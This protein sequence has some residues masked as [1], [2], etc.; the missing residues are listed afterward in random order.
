MS[1]TRASFTLACTAVG[2]LIAALTRTEA[3]QPV[4]SYQVHRDVIR[5]R[6]TTD[7]GK[8]ISLADI[9]IT[10]APDRVTQFGKSDSAGR[11][12]IV[13]ERGTG[14]YLV[15]IA[16]LGREAFRKRVTRTGAD[17]VFVVDASLKSSVQQLAP[18][19]VQAARTRIP[20]EM[21]TSLPNPVG[22]KEETAGNGVYAT[23]SPDQRGNLDAIAAVVPGISAVSGGGVSVLGLAPSQNGA[24]LNGLAFEGGS[25]P[26]GA[27]T[28]STVASSTYDPSR[29]GF[30]GAQTQVTLSPGD[31]NVSRRAYLTFDSPV[32]QASDPI[33]A[34]AGQQY[35]ALDL[36]LGTA[37]ATNMDRWV[38]NTGL[39]LKRQMSDV[40]SL[41]A[42]DSSVLSHAGV[43]LD[44]VSR[45]L[46]AL[47][48]LGIPSSARGV[49]DSRATDVVNFMGRLDRPLFDYNT[50][51]PQNTTWGITGFANRAHTGALNFSPTATPAHGGE[52]TDLAAGVQADYSAYFG[53]KKDQLND[54]KTGVSVR[55]VTTS[56]YVT[57]PDGR[58]LVSSTLDDARGGVASLAF[59]GNSALDAERTVATW[60]TT[61]ETY[62]F[63]RGIAAHRGK[64]Y[65]DSRLDQYSIDN[66][67]NRLGTYSYNSLADLQANRPASFTRTLSSPTRTG[68]EWSGAL[69]L[70]DNWIKSTHLSMI[71]GARLET[72]AFTSTP[73]ANPDIERLFGAATNHAPNTWHVSPRVG[74]NWYYTSARPVN[75]VSVNPTG[76]FYTVPRGVIRGGIGEFRQNVDPTL[77]SEASVATGLPGGATQLS[78]FGDAV[79]S[80]NWQSFSASE[81]SIPSQC[82]GGS[83]TAGLTDAAPNVLLFDRHY[84]PARSWRGNLGWASAVKSVMYVVDA[85]YAVHLNQPS[86]TDLNFAHASRFTL[87][88]EGDRPVFVPASSIVPASGVIAPAAAR[89]TQQY[90]QVLSRLSDLRGWARQASLRLRPN[91]LF[92]GR[93]NLDATYTF[94]DAH[95][96]SRGFDGTT[97]GDPSRIDWTRADYAPRHEITMSAGFSHPL[98]GV[99]LF[100][101]ATSGLPFTPMVGSDINGDGLANDRA[102]VADPALTTDPAL[103][104]GLRSLLATTSSRSRDCLSDQLNKPAAK[105]SCEGPWTAS[106]NMALS[107]GY[108]LNR[109]LPF[110]SH[111]PQISLYVSNPLGG[112]DQLMHGNSLKGWGTPSFPDRVLYY[113]RGFD[114]TAR[115]FRYEVNP[116]FGNTRPST[117]TLRV[118]FRVTL[119]VTMSFGPS[120][121]E[122]Q[123]NRMLR[124]GRNGNPGPKLD[125][126]GIVRRYCGNLPDWYGEIL[127]QA[128]SL[129]L[130]REQVDALQ[131][132]KTAYIARVREHWGRFAAH[133]AAI[134]DTYDVQDLVK[135]QSD[136]SNVAWDIARDEAQTTLPKILTPVQLKI[137][138]GN[139][140]F[141]F[142]S[143]DPIRNV[144]FFSTL[145][146]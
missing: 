4:T 95:M 99:S 117:T 100:G 134:P 103:A 139:S 47:D 73:A 70:A 130:T 44:S 78:C 85:T 135:Q 21:G 96:Q 109:K 128:D 114:S 115:Q 36:N 17:S 120:L 113:V 49:P 3:Q 129:L 62:F 9:A 143:K 22:G 10:M 141:I 93:W 102:F 127:Q 90:G 29:G 144:R 61:N 81:S 67:F 27:R 86:S 65:A 77:L 142:E 123:I 83:A 18:V 28:Q 59:A 119:D 32:L 54:V 8:A 124:A 23:V 5:G 43:A 66:A 125:S 56:P 13:F 88:N 97:F 136:A 87:P 89:T 20:R 131:A 138:P 11:Y 39:E 118:P 105:N 122:Q 132:A 50:F 140:R 6:V 35:T 16:A 79:P 75:G 31:I 64:L 55:H 42:A 76:I 111:N 74:F 41:L 1:R 26:R 101:K 15:H 121:D 25:V 60:E 40:T 7:S 45:L 137:L 107:P 12:E 52:T 30:S 63:W 57:L 24:T 19:A 71:Y 2:L 58:V 46:S 145:S 38:Y 72:N 69:S 48:A 116:R 34:R 84:Q 112:L 82:A 51:T 126:A 98:F 146:C 92:V 108:Q 33:A 53:A 94:T 14:D 106:F 104:A 110:R 133:L 80:P 91:V 68:G 37:G